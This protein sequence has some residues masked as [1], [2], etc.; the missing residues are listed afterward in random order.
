LTLFSGALQA[1]RLPEFGT[2]FVV[3][4]VAGAINAAIAAAYYLRVISVMYFRVSRREFGC[5]GGWGAQAAMV[6]ATGL[7][8]VVGLFPGGVTQA[9]RN[10]EFSLRRPTVV[11]NEQR[12][13]ATVVSEAKDRS[14]STYGEESD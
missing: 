12:A 4:A 14:A 6:L 8:V 9:T 10:A 2:W 3:L 5:E 11:G 13:V 7:V 1:A